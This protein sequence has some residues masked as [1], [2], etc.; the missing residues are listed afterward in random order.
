MISPR[1]VVVL[2][3]DREQA[4]AEQRNQVAEVTLAPAEILRVR[5]GDE[6]VRLRAEHEDRRASAGCG[7]VKIGPCRS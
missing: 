7:H 5:D 4:V 6:V 3:V 1:A 2:A